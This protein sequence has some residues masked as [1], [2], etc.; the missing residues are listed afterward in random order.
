RGQV[1]RAARQPEGGHAGGH[2]TARHDEHAV[3]RGP[4]VDDLAAQLHDGGEIDDAP[5]V[6][7]RRRPDLGDDR[8]H[9]ASGSYSKLKSPTHTTS[10]GRAPARARARS[11]PRRLSRAS[12]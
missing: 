4:E 7:E 12:A 2:G 3:A 6:G 10:P 5:L 1:G 11:T 9:E 8:A